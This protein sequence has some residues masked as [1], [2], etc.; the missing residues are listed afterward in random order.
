MTDGS[1]VRANVY[2]RSQMSE[3]AA[4]AAGSLMGSG[5]GV[6]GVVTVGGRVL[7]RVTNLSLAVSIIDPR[8]QHLMLFSRAQPCTGSGHRTPRS[9]AR[10]GF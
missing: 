1:S 9:R 2:V 10:S 7:S 8:R 6:A 3:R 5:V 4:A